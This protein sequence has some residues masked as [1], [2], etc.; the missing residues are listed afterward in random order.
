MVYTVYYI[1]INIIIYISCVFELQ[2]HENLLKQGDACQQKMRK[3]HL[4]ESSEITN[5]QHGQHG[6]L[7]PFDSMGIL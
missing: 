4:Q 2:A 1:C 3:I 5:N 7:T 6:L